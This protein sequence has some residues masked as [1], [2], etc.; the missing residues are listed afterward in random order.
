MESSSSEHFQFWK[1]PDLEI[2]VTPTS[3]CVKLE[4]GIFQIWKLPDLEIS[5]SRYWPLEMKCCTGDVRGA[6]LI[7]H[8]KVWLLSLLLCCVAALL[9]ALTPRFLLCCSAI[10]FASP[11]LFFSFLLCL[12]L[13]CSAFSFGVARTTKL[14]MYCLTLG[15]YFLR[16]LRF[17]NDCFEPCQ[18]MCVWRTFGHLCWQCHWSIC[19]W[20]SHC[21]TCFLLLSSCLPSLPRLSF[22]VVLSAFILFSLCPCCRAN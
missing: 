19:C 10:C 13:C 6:R 2:S 12:L 11:M 16:V 1:F 4:G 7:F 9:F 15:E 18:H 8:L 22:L 5:R 21:L 17:R 14:E 3:P 20:V